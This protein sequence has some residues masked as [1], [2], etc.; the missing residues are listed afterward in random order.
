MENIVIPKK[1]LA[2]FVL[3]ITV[4]FTVLFAMATVYAATVYNAGGGQISNLGEPIVSSDAATKNYVDGASFA[5]KVYEGDGTTEVGYFL[6]WNMS[7]GGDL[8]PAWEV[9]EGLRYSDTSTGTS[10]QMGMADCITAYTAQYIYYFSA[11]C[12]DAA[13]SNTD[14]DTYKYQRAGTYTFDVSGTFGGTGTAVSRRHQT[15]G[16]CSDGSWGINKYYASSITPTCGTTDDC[17]IKE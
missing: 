15:T 7:G 3:G 4:T 9:C 6:G 8:N 10:S 5:L 14:G 2:R 13:Y 12:A 1:N 16:S 11:S 17:K